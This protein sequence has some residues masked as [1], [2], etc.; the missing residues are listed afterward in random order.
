MKSE[1]QQ[2][3]PRPP[4]RPQQRDTYPRR[5]PVSVNT[6]DSTSPQHHRQQQTP[7]QQGPSSQGQN[8]N[9]IP[10]RPPPTDP[11]KLYYHFCGLG[12][13]HTTKQCACFA[14]G[15][16]FQE[17]QQAASSTPKLVNHTRRQ[18]NPPQNQPYHY[19]PI[20]YSIPSQQP[21]YHYPTYQQHNH[22]PQS[23]STFEHSYHPYQ[24]QPRSNSQQ[25][26]MTRPPTPP[27][28]QHQVPA[29]PPP[30]PLPTQPAQ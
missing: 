6:I 23:Y 9:N 30:P 18:P 12:K 13:G 3:Q 7:R 24:Y 25:Y 26:T 16:E 2:A 19:T 20:H 17:A 15:K 22:A 28:P 27:Q 11:S 4:P 5:E 14:K 29:L 1:A 21:H 8:R 10:N